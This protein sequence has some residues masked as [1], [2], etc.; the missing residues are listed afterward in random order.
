MGT[1][2]I[3]QPQWNKV[4][5]YGHSLKQ[6][7]FTE[8]ISHPVIVISLIIISLLISTAITVSGLKGAIIILAGMLGITLVAAIFIN[9]R[10]GIIVILIMAYFIMWILRMGVNFP[11]GTLMDGMEALLII[12]FF[13]QQKKEKN[14]KIF[15]NPISIMVGI[16]IIYILLQVVNPSSESRLAWVYTVRSTALVMLLYFIFLYNIRTVSFIRLI[17][18]LWLALSVFAAL[19]AFKQEYFGFFDFEDSWLMSDPVIKDLLFIGGSWRKFS[20]FSDPVAFAY[21]MAVACIL[22]IAL[23]TGPFSAK[24]KTML[25]FMAAFFMLVMLY[26]GTRGAYVLVPAA[27]ILLSILKF[28]RTIMLATAVAAFF[29]GIMIFIPTS[30]STLVRFQ[31]AFRPSEDASFNV[32]KINQK[33]IQPYIQSNPL[34]GGLG[35][36]GTWGKRFS[37]G[38]YLANF[39]PD[40]GYVRTAVEL[41]SIGLLIFCIFMF[42]CL[43]TGINNFYRINDPELKT[44]CLAMTLIVFALNIGNYPQEA[45]VQFPIS[46]YFYLTLAIINVSLMLSQKAGN[47]YFQKQE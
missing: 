15:K 32:R 31:S 30:N 34:G 1:Q 23:I 11:L 10:I 36:T 2:F 4:K 7:I 47:P 12:G 29:M 39:P 28:S 40:S 18:K 9:N 6:S 38:S 24:K 35:A 21:N 14:W 3:I 16:W 17:L 41:G 45:L 37:P 25:S 19:Y 26:S 44:Y 43:R 5:A 22:C 42:T 20:I 13:L 8:K 46:I 27:L 33:R